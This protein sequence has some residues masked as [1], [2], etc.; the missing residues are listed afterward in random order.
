MNYKS[1]WII[2]HSH[3]QICQIHN[4]DYINKALLVAVLQQQFT[5]LL[6]IVTDLLTGSGWEVSVFLQNI[7]KL[8]R[9]K[10]GRTHQAYWGMSYNK[11]YSCKA[12]YL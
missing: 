8:E 12:S 1:L 11:H 6:F 9:P 3:S 5:S 2:N 7:T 10:A 4:S